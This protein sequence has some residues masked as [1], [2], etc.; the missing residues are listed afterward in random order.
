MIVD[1]NAL[2]FNQ[3]AIIAMTVVA[4]VLG[5]SAA[6]WLV[7]ITAA[8][9]LLGT[10]YAPASGFKLLY[11]H[12]F[13]RFGLLK[14]RPEPDDP[15]PHQF[16]Q[17][18]GGTFLALA[19]AALLAGW[20]GVAWTLTWVVILLAGVNLVLGFCLGCFVFFQLQRSGVL[21]RSAEVH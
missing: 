21:H 19:F 7:G 1:R 18:L 10:A 3:A 20:T 2:R 15:A 4:F 6:T 14:P 17:G 5:G 16:A 13:V 12:L 11:R 8:V 9:M